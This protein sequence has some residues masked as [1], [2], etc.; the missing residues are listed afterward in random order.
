MG[1]V[2]RTNAMAINA[3]RQLNINNNQVANSLQ[4]L[5][6]GYKI[7]SA[8]D[9]AS[10]LAISEKMKSQ[11]A[12]LDTASDN[13]QDGISLV[14]TAEGATSQIHSMLNR[15][16]ELSTKSANGTI[17]DE[18]DRE[19]I[20]SEVDA[21]NSEITRIAES[22]E[23]NG[24]TLLDGSLGGGSITTDG[25]AFSGADVADSEAAELTTAVVNNADL[26]NIDTAVAAI[27][28]L[29]IDGQTVKIDWT[30]SDNAA[31]TALLDV[32]YS[33]TALAADVGDD[34][35]TKLQDT[36]NSAMEDQGV[37]GSV[38]VE[39]DSGAGTFSIKSDNEDYDSEVS[40]LGSTD[41]SGTA[42]T[43]ANIGT[44][45][46]G[47]L[48][49]PTAAAVTSTNTATVT[50]DG[51]DVAA[52]DKFQMKINGTTVSVTMTAGITNGDDMD[53][54]SGVLQTDVR[55]AV[56]AYNTQNNLVSG[57][58]GYLDSTEFTVS[59]G[60]NGNFVVEYSGDEDCSFSFSDVN[61]GTTASD[62]GLEGGS[63][64]AGGNQGLT[65]QIGD[66]ADSFNM[67]NVAIDNLSAVGIGTDN[68]DVSTAD[69]AADAIETINNAINQ[70]STNR[71]NLGAIQ[72]RLEYTID[73]LDNTSENITSA[74]SQIR[75]T[76]MATEM[77]SYTQSNI[78]LQAAQS[79]L[80]QANSAPQA[81]LQL[82]Q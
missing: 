44:S 33:G 62:L 75:D 20:Q 4:K 30:D 5:S 6:S 36:I 51:T 49:D 14:Q 41:S 26:T 60:D 59:A 73:N 45:V 82:L 42:V 81:V 3:N 28:V 54:A 61:D 9:D 64:K 46:M 47:N 18:V 31:L 16:V 66:S 1:M 13:A 8:A 34:I 22:T 69:A 48:V 68:L 53:T 10:G 74:N 38:S 15:M 24:I 80:A 58:D 12:G 35:A 21:L 79:M 72:N 11:I 43:V 78:L 25:S 2:V 19:A 77:M 23:F 55:T 40:Y 32:D 50:Y 17:Q 63:S 7:N 70:V 37:T 52:A 57:D 56:D 27:D 71:A 67:V 76:D 29:S 65:L 39:Y